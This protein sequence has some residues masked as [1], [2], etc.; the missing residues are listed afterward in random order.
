MRLTID[1]K[2]LQQQLSAVNKVI[3]SKNALTILDN[4]LFELEGSQLTITGSDQENTVKVRVEVADS[5]GRGRIAIPAKTILEI[6]KEISNQPV[7]FILND[8]TGEI[9]L[10]FM[11]GQFRFMGINADEFPQGDNLEDASQSFSLP[12]SVVLKGIEKTVYAVSSENIRPIMT[13]IYWD[14]HENDIVFVASDTHKLVRYITREVSPGFERG[15]IMPAKPANILKGIMGKED[16]LNIRIGEKG[17]CFTFGDFSLTCRFIKGNYPNYNRVIP[18]DNPYTVTIERQSMLNAMRRVAIFA[19]KASNLVKMEMQPG[20][21][22]L[23]A[24][25]LDYGTSA[26][27]RVM[28]DYQGDDMTIGFNSVFTLEILNNMGG[29]TTVIKLS[30]PARPG[31]FEPLEQEPETELTT[32]QMPMQVIE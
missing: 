2:L 15:F 21:M 27:E 22:R 23:A 6:T 5:D 32:I 24:Q 7:S 1:G 28:C 9:D 25:D 20:I 16:M 4:F 14:I 3:N 17:A 13:G 12:A 8:Q 29:E 18:T 11:N 10:Q 26:E 30:D 19:S 31:I